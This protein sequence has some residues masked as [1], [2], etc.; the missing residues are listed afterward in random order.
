MAHTDSDVVLAQAIQAI[1]ETNKVTLGLD[2]VF[3]GNQRMLP[4]ASSAVV[5][6]EGKARQLAGVTAPG[7]RTMNELMVSID[8]HRSKVGVEADE[9]EAVD[10]IATDVETLLH[11]DTTIGGIIIHGFI[12]SVQRGEI[13]FAQN[14][15]FRSVHMSFV[16]QTKT[17]LSP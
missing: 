14:S 9:R 2:D 5:I 4:R 17:Y 10:E 6:A 13:E 15:M 11:S 16:G 12:R 3:Y 7:G 1:L 8:I